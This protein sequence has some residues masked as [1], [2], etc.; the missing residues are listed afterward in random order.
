MRNALWLLGLLSCIAVTS[1]FCLDVSPSTLPATP[2]KIRISW[3]EF[4]G[5]KLVFIF[6]GDRNDSRGGRVGA[7]TIWPPPGPMPLGDLPERLKVEAQAALDEPLRGRKTKELVVIEGTTRSWT[8][9][10]GTYAGPAQSRI[11]DLMNASPMPK[12]RELVMPDLKP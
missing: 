6:D 10:I 5:D 7:Y 3:K 12:A 2:P 8:V 4:E 9:R 11:I 1:R